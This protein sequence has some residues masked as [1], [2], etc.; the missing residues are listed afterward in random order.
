MY[1]GLWMLPGHLRNHTCRSRLH[2]PQ[3]LK[4]LYH[5]SCS[6]NTHCF[7]IAGCCPSRFGIT[8]RHHHC[9]EEIGRISSCIARHPLCFMIY[10]VPVW[11]PVLT[12]LSSAAHFPSSSPVQTSGTLAVSRVLAA[13]LRATVFRQWCRNWVSTMGK[14]LGR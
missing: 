1:M 12:G 9:L 4:W 6:L 5:L 10:Q 11:G 8:V 3:I 7:Q 14:S 2:S 13:G